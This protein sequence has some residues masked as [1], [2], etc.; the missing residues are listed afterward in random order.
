MGH[1]YIQFISRVFFIC[2]P[3]LTGCSSCLRL[4]VSY[5][6]SALVN[7]SMPFGFCSS[8]ISLPWHI[9]FPW[10]MNISYSGSAESRR[11]SC[12]NYLFMSI[13]WYTL[14]CGGI[15]FTWLICVDFSWL[16]A[17]IFFIWWPLFTIQGIIFFDQVLMW[18]N[19]ITIVCLRCWVVFFTSSYRYW[20]SQGSF[21]LGVS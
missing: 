3:K 15:I 12:S 20:L 2:I 1:K 17:D 10:Y 16:T 8:G 7:F 6:S 13:G 21:P 11:Y 4:L 18:E 14:C 9:L 19:E 5:Y